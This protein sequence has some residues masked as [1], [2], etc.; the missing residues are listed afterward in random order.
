MSITHYHVSMAYALITP[1]L[2]Q[3]AKFHGS[4]TL[5]SLDFIFIN[6]LFIVS[7]PRAS[8]AQRALNQLYDNHL[9]SLAHIARNSIRLLH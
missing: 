2:H 6:L 9:Y 1:S 4:Q 3:L 5:A 8:T 7:M